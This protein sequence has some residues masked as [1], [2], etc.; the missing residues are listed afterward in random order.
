ML[1]FVR[2]WHVS[3][4]NE[5]FSL[6]WV[7]VLWL[8]TCN[9]CWKIL[10]WN[11]DP[12]SLDY[13]AFDSLILCGNESLGLW[14]LQYC[15]TK[16]RDT[17]SMSL[18]VSGPPRHL[19]R[20]SQSLYWLLFRANL[21][22]NILS[23]TSI[24][25]QAVYCPSCYSMVLFRARTCDNDGRSPLTM[26]LS[27]FRTFW[28]MNE[29]TR[30]IRGAVALLFSMRGQV[31]AVEDCGPFLMILFWLG[32]LSQIFR[33]K[34]GAYLGSIIAVKLKFRVCLGQIVYGNW[35]NEINEFRLGMLG[36]F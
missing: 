27:S 30:S 33:W 18:Q 9:Y 32:N 8:L 26:G 21:F 3:V 17:C 23:S 34:F 19:M 1:Q 31:V 14:C 2:I 35:L 5:S 20:T 29:P 12:F 10:V 28:S 11:T 22:K 4:N 6:I 13:P 16:C 25:Y 24:G 15:T 36:W 7:F